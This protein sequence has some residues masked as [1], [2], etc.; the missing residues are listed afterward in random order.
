MKSLLCSSKGRPNNSPITTDEI[1]V[2]LSILRGIGE[3]DATNSP[4]TTNE[5]I[6]LLSILRDIGYNKYKITHAPQNTILYCT[7]LGFYCAV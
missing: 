6:V 1:I 4:I 3:E 2:L 5:I 7:F